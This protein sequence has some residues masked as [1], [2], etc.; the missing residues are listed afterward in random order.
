MR[1]GR[2]VWH[3]AGSGVPRHGLHSVLR[4]SRACVSC[5][6]F[7]RHKWLSV[8]V[9]N[10]VSLEDYVVPGTLEI[11]EEVHLPWNLDPTDLVG[12]TRVVFACCTERQRQVGSPC[13]SAVKLFPG[14]K[15]KSC[16]PRPQSH[17]RRSSF[18]LDFFE[19]SRCR[20][21]GAC[22]WQFFP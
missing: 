18:Y 4:L 13:Y 19:C 14:W 8:N 3:G 9:E 11:P 20:I 12:P 5:A 15:K 1:R 16:G 7:L 22:W 21:S 10:P 6:Y 2:R 17:I